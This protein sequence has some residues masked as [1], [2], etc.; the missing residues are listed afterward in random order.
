MP[1][2]CSTMSQAPVMCSFLLHLH[3]YYVYCTERWATIIV[4]KQWRAEGGANGAPAPGI[5]GKGASKE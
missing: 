5:Q 2:R 3:A 4:C 1:Y